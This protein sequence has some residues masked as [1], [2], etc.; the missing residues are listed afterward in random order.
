MVIVLL[1]IT[2]CYAILSYRRNFIWKDDLTL[3]NDIVHKSPKKAR[4]YN[5]RGL[6]YDEQGNFTQA[7]SDYN[8][9]IEINPNLATM[10]IITVGLPILNKVTCP[11][12]SLTL[13]RP[14]K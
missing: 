13:P 7:I 2:S 1:I 4:P 14:L 9:A 10:P 8:K 11:K 6:A 3:W 5:N 12:P